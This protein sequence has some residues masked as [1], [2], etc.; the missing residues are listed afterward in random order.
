VDATERELPVALPAPSRGRA[1]LVFGLALTIAVAA[2]VLLAL[3]TPVPGPVRAIEALTVM[4]LVG[5]VALAPLARVDAVLTRR[6][7]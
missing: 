6:R 4:V 2:A 7:R 3:A 5:G 1:W